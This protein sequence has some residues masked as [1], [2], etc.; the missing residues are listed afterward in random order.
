MPYTSTQVHNAH[1][2]PAKQWVK[3]SDFQ[4]SMFNGLYDF[5]LGNQRIINASPS[6]EQLPFEQWRVIAW[7]AAW[8]ATSYVPDKKGVVKG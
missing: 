8:S 1:S 3:W 7:N 4:R 5:L 2:V 6:F